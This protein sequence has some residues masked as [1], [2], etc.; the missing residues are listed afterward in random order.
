MSSFMGES[1][2][3][4]AM[5]C[6]GRSSE[7]ERS[8]AVAAAL[9]QMAGDDKLTRFGTG[10]SAS[11]TLTQQHTERHSMTTT[12]GV[13]SP[14]IP[15]FQHDTQYPTNLAT[16]LLSKS[17]Q[18]EVPSNH[19]FASSNDWTGRSSGACIVW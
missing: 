3:Y 18:R 6:C 5:P 13:H 19:L 15:M 1:T 9:H 8:H 2:S 14:R 17:Y 16:L 10:M 12:Q 7:S 4:G 11:R